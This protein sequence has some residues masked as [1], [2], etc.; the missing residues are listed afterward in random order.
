MAFSSQAPAGGVA[1]SEITINY[2]W[3][4]VL[5]RYDPASGR[6]LRWIDNAVHSDGISGEQVR[7]SNVVVVFAPHVEVADICEEVR[8]GVCLHLSVQP[9]IWGSG[10]AI[11]FRD[12]QRFDVTWRRENR[13]DML[14][15][16][17]AAGNPAPLQLGNSWLQVVPSQWA[18]PVSS[19]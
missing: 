15:F 5:W 8:N 13:N 1:A 16:Y 14:T 4:T 18:G 17:D 6:Y 12:G 9:Q 10:S 3:A 7:A 19:R 2:N 11:I